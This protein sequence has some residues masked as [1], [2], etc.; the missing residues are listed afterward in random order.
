MLEGTGIH[1]AN[2]GREGRTEERG[3]QAEGQADGQTRGQNRVHGIRLE[4]RRMTALTGIKTQRHTEKDADK[5]RERDRDTEKRSSREKNVD[6][7]TK[8]QRQ[9]L[10]ERKRERM[11][12]KHMRIKSEEVIDAAG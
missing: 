2:I 9:R 8:T 1:Y 6:T 4:E 5:C 11:R 3:I 12:K 10:R 7:D